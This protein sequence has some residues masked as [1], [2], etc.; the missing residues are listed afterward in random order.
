MDKTQFIELKGMSFFA[1]HGVLEQEKKVGNT[2]TVDLK[3]YTDLSKAM[4]TDG[5]EDTINYAAVYEIVKEEMKKRSQ[6][7]EH[8]AGRIINH[9]K[10][11]FPKITTVEIRLAKLN[12]P[13]SGDI[14]E[15]AVII[16]R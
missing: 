14:K 3:L 16:K 13:I 5:L 2:Y 10:Q 4:Q 12:P 8:V 9:T 7:L 6:L 1:Y 15:A 11:S